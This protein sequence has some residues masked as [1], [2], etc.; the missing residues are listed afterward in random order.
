[1]GLLKVLWEGHNRPVWC[2]SWIVS[3]MSWCPPDNVY[4]WT[5][6]ILHGDGRITNSQMAFLHETGLI[7]LTWRWNSPIEVFRVWPCRV[8]MPSMFSGIGK[9]KISCSW[10]W[11]ALFAVSEGSSWPYV[12]A[13]CNHQWCWENQNTSEGYHVL[14]YVWLQPVFTSAAA[15]CLFLENQEMVS[16]MRPLITSNSHLEA[17]LACIFW[18]GCGR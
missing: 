8:W 16:S 11:N 5:V 18:L 7:I 13:H 4:C 6:T 10:E 1:M 2:S 12:F 15:F 14:E 3:C 17:I 9:L